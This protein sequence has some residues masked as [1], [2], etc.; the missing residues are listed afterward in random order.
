[1]NDEYTSD[2]KS[3]KG[4]DGKLYAYEL[5]DLKIK[6]QLVVLSACNGGSGRIVTGEGMMSLGRSFAYAGTPSILASRWPVPDVSAPYLM[7]YFYEGLKKGMR[8]SESL[9]YAQNQFIKNNADNIT[10]AP[11]YWSGFYIIGDDSPI[12]VSNHFP[13]W[14]LAMIIL[15]VALSPLPFIRKKLFST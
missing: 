9:K 2:K 11:L 14:Q 13:W 3:T 12:D 15:L 5:Y 7:K 4:V 8:K 6:S 1:M 10:S